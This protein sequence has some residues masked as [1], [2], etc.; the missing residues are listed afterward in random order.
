MQLK[1]GGSILNV[2]DAGTSM[3]CKTCWVN[4]AGLAIQVRRAGRPVAAG[5]GGGELFFLPQRPYM[6]LG[7][8]RDQLLYPTW[9]GGA[10]DRSASPV[11][12][13]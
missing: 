8:L 5:S 9:A 3:S 13:R 4:P 1:I 2:L 6:V 12:C 7:S 10:A 11:K